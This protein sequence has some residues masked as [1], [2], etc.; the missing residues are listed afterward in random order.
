MNAPSTPTQAIGSTSLILD[1]IRAAGTI[2]RVG[3]SK[4][5]GLTGAT[6]SNAVRKLIDDDLVVEIGR[7]ESTGGKPRVLLELNPSARFAVGVHLDHGSITYVLANLAGSQV[8]RMSRAGAGGDTPETVVDRIA[9]E[10]HLLIESAGIERERVLGIGLVSPGPLTSRAGMHLTPPFMR[11]WADFPLDTR[12]SEATGYGV[13]LEND[14][15][16]SAIGEYWSGG[17]DG[18]G[19]FAALYME[20]GLGAGLLIGGSPYRGASSNAGEIGHT[21]ADINGPQ[22]WC[23]MHGCIELYAG[24]P[25]IVAQ[26]RKIPELALLAGLTELP[27]NANI[28]QQFAAIGRA[29]LAGN[30]AAT[31]L[32]ER[33]AKYVAHAAHT[34]ANTLDI[35][36]LVLTGA[37]F[38][39]ASHIYIPAI[40]K[41]LDS[42]F[43]ARANHQ[44]EVRLSQSAST[45]ASIGA[46]AL[47]LQAELIPHRS[48]SL[49]KNVRTAGSVS[50]LSTLSS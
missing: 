10:I 49:A 6:V 26:A 43:F 50:E 45:A 15:T 44:V 9:K 3:I 5:T 12:L 39:A 7:A 46:A 19:T 1:A 24:P 20:T 35:Q 27:E 23:G 2:S 17:T 30:L 34:L 33:S 40:R 21:S 29:S 37:S 4:V 8:A 48:S 11:S 28:S 31:E 42:T 22:C 32:L 36:M 13:I 25:V 16:A 47:I 18:E 41:V 38:T 14:A